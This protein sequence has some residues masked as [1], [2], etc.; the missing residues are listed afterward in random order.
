[1]VLVD[2]LAAVCTAWEV[3]LGFLLYQ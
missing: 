1:V 3:V 2:E